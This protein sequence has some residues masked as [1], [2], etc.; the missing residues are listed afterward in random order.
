MIQQLILF[1]IFTSSA[2]AD[3]QIHYVPE[4][5]KGD[6][7]SPERVTMTYNKDD[8]GHATLSEALSA[9]KAQGKIEKLDFIRPHPFTEEDKFQRELIAAFKELAPE[10]W[11]AAERSAGNMHNPK[12]SPLWR[13]LSE[14]FMRTS[15]AK[16]ISRDL[17]PYGMVITDFGHEKLRY[18]QVDGMRMIR[19]IFHVSIATKKEADQAVRGN[20]ET[21]TK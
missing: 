13:Y 18:E 14:A 12:I 5:T 3:W 2:I 4:V 6:Y 15:L 17:V 11:A 10:E 9:L 20:A 7:H 21:T 8:T 19:G 16:E 1:C